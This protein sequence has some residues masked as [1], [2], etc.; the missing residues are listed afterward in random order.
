MPNLKGHIAIASVATAAIDYSK[1]VPFSLMTPESIA[2]ILIGTILPDLDHQ[3]STVNQKILLVNRKWFQT[4]VYTLL[5]GLIIYYKGTE[6]K[7]I[8]AAGILVLTG[9]LPHRA[10]THKPLGIFLIC[11]CTYLF[12]GFSPLGRG[13]IFG[14]LVHIFADRVKDIFY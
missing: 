5:A 12:L 13:I 1:L 3:S 7:N 9:F 14:V 10:F 11:L 8:L 4:V 2:G 6:L